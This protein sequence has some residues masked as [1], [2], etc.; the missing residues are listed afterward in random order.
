MLIVLEILFILLSLLL[1][2][3]ILI[4]PP[5]GEGLASAFGGG[6]DTFFGTKT[7]Q[8]I[9]RFTIIVSVIIL[10]LTILINIVA[11]PTGESE[12]PDDQ[13]AKTEAPEDNKGE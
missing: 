2:A 10:L 9:N 12:A 8:H 13:P 1:I 5:K 11:F 6:G 7:T 4:Q 3:V